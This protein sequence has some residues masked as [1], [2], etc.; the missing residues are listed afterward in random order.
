MP[1][2]TK[3]QVH[4]ILK[5]PQNQQLLKL[6]QHFYT[7]LLRVNGNRVDSLEEMTR[8]RYSPL[9]S[10]SSELEVLSRIARV[11]SG[12]DI[13]VAVS[14][15]QHRLVIA[16]N[17]EY[18]LTKDLEYITAVCNQFDSLGRAHRFVFIDGEKSVPQVHQAIVNSV[19]GDKHD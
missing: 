2:L 18:S 7:R 16:T 9:S 13:C 15:D 4:K 5:D 8:N 19:F 14:R 1:K 6:I 11:L 17:K 3:D 12:T 10:R